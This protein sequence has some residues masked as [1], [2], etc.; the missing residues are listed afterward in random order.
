MIPKH[1][2]AEIAPH[3]FTHDAMA[4]TFEIAIAG[5]EANYARQVAAECF[6]VIDNLERE[7][8]RFVESSDISQINSLAAGESA[9]IGLH[10]FECLRLAADVHA[11]TG[12]AFDVTVGPYLNCWREARALSLQ[13]SSEEIASARAC[14]GMN[15]LDLDDREFSVKVRSEGIEVDLG[16][17]GKGYALDQAAKLLPDWDI[18][19]A[20]INAGE[21]TV[22]AIGAP[23][24]ENGWTLG[25]GGGTTDSEA[26]DQ[27]RL[28]DRALSGSGIAVQGGHII[29]P[30]SGLP[31][32]EK[33]AAW[34]VCES[35]ATADALSS[36][37]MVMPC[38]EVESF[39]K[40]RPDISAML[41]IEEDD[42][43]KTLRFGNW[44]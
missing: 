27:I 15:L 42:S 18:D 34:V 43:G 28:R 24:G 38:S 35:A 26:P 17:I 1:E 41:L 39:C 31:A 29:D 23:P 3:R 40:N 19:A 30:T 22:L 7:L 20:L 33:A 2:S 25:V 4:T 44:P 6:T 13:P 32:T 14:V 16:G 10:A 9:R 8:S 36:A 5:K 11:T 37:F 21:S 12:G